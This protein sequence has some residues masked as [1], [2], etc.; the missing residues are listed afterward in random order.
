MTGM[1]SPLSLASAGCNNNATFHKSKQKKRSRH[2][3]KNLACQRVPA[4]VVSNANTVTGVIR[5]RERQQCALGLYV[6][7]SGCRLTDRA[8]MVPNRRPTCNTSK[9]KDGETRRHLFISKKAHSSSGN[10]SRGP[11]GTIN[12]RIKTQKKRKP[13]TLRGDDVSTQSRNEEHVTSI[14]RAHYEDFE[15]KSGLKQSK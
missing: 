3:A 8:P 12:K 10:D 4:L 7:S 5:L 11:D 1:P 6:F 2:R 15:R 9:S 13:K 14:V